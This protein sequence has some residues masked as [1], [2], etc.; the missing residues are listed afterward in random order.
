MRYTLSYMKKVILVISFIAICVGSYI[1]FEGFPVGYQNGH[2]IV[3]THNII[4]E[5]LCDVTLFTGWYQK[6]RGNINEIE[7]S[8]IGGDI[9]YMLNQST[10]EGSYV[11]CT[12]KGE[13]G[14]SFPA[15]FFI[16]NI[17]NNE[18]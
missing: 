11:A 15:K 1:V 17:S 3:F 6:F 4:C 9:V 14:F 5:D 7:C 13:K 16:K 18:I 12:P 10:P 2:V 8:K